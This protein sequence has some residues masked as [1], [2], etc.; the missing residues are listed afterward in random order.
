LGIGG[1]NAILPSAMH[2]IVPGMVAGCDKAFG[3]FR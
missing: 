1:Q 3:P 2:K